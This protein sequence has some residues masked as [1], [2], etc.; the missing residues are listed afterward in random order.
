[1][2]IIV[3]DTMMVETADTIKENQGAD[4]E[5]TTFKKTENM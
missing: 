1:M 4:T 2:T 5:M 3:I